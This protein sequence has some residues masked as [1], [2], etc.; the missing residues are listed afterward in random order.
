MLH[1]S[2]DNFGDAKKGRWISGEEMRK[3]ESTDPE[4]KKKLES[5]LVVLD[6]E[7]NLYMTPK[8]RPT[9]GG[10]IGI[11]HS[12]LIGTGQAQFAEGGTPY[13]NSTRTY[14]HMYVFT[15]PY[16][17]SRSCPDPSVRVSV[18]PS[19]PPSERACV[20]ACVRNVARRI[21]LLIKN[22]QNT[23]FWF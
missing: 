20:R 4:E 16:A 21:S 12:S 8:V 17:G 7:S 1:V 15:F 3:I 9:T 13:P 19:I 10:L 14:K 23:F 18:H 11:Q 6:S 2:D 22:I 5:I